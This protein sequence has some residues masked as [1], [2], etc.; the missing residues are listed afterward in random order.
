M[1]NNNSIDFLQ[2]KDDTKV[3]YVRYDLQDTLKTV[4]SIKD[5]FTNENASYTVSYNS[6]E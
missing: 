4:N 2:K 5:F 1:Y 3:K 6:F